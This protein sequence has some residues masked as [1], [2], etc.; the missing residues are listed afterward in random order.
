MGNPSGGGHQAG[1]GETAGSARHFRGHPQPVVDDLGA[2][3][4]PQ[5]PTVCSIPIRCATLNLGIGGLLNCTDDVAQLMQTHELDVLGVTETHIPSGSLVQDLGTEDGGLFSFLGP[6]STCAQL[7]SASSRPRGGVGLLFRC[8]SSLH[9]VSAVLMPDHD[10]RVR[11]HVAWFTLELVDERATAIVHV[12]VVYIPPRTSDSSLL[13]CDDR[14]CCAAN[15]ARDHTAAIMQQIRDEGDLLSRGNTGQVLL[16]GDFNAM[17]PIVEGNWEYCT[18][19]SAGA[20]RNWR[21][22]EPVLCPQRQVPYVL[23]NSTSTPLPTRI[24]PSSRAD[25][26]QTASILDLVLHQPASGSSVEDFWTEEVPGKDH[27]LVGFVFIA[28]ATPMAVVARVVAGGPPLFVTKCTPETHSRCRLTRIA[29]VQTAHSDMQWTRASELYDSWW[30]RML[31]AGMGPTVEEVNSVAASVLRQC[32]LLLSRAAAE[33]QDP[34]LLQLLQE[35]G[36][37]VDVASVNHVLLHKISLC[38]R[39]LKRTRAKLL[40]LGSRDNQDSARTI[41]AIAHRR[42]LLVT[43]QEA[44]RAAQIES[45]SHSRELRRD[46]AAAIAALQAEA[47]EAHDAPFRLAR[48]LGAITRTPSEWRAGGRHSKAGARVRRPQEATFASLQQWRTYLE[49]KYSPNVPPVPAELL[50]RLSVPVVDKHRMSLLDRDVAPAEVESALGQLR[51]EAAALAVPVRAFKQLSLAAPHSLQGLAIMLTSFLRGAPLPVDVTTVTLYPIL[52]PGKDAGSKDNWR[53]IGFGTTVSRVLQTV[54]ANRLKAFIVETKCL[55]RA[56]AGF[57][58]KLSADMMCWLTTVITEDAVLAGSPQFNSFVDVKAAFASTSH[59]DVAQSLMRVGIQ[60]DLASL[61]MS[62][63]TQS[64]VYIAEDGFRCDSVPATLGLIEGCSFSPLL[65]NIVMDSLLCKLDTVVQALVD[66]GLD[67]APLLDTASPLPATAYADDVRLIAHSIVV[68]QELLTATN[69]WMTEHGLQLGVASDKTAALI[70]AALQRMGSHSA[71]SALH[72]GDRELPLVSFY[73]YLGLLVHWKGV[74]ASAKAHRAMVLSRIRSAIGHLRFSGIRQ[75]RPNVGIIAYLTR[76]RPKLTYGLAMW[77]LCAPSGLTDLISDDY[78]AQSVLMNADGPLPHVVMN[79]LLCIPTLQCELDRCVVRLL[80]RLVALPEDDMYRSYLSRKCR[81]WNAASAGGRDR[82]K[83]TWWPRALARLQRLDSSVTRTPAS[84]CPYRDLGVR[85]ADTIQRMLLE[86]EVESPSAPSV[87][88]GHGALP[89]DQDVAE[90]F[91]VDVVGDWRPAMLA[92]LDR[93]MLYVTD[94][95][96]WCDNQLSISRM[97]S[98]VDTRDLVMGRPWDGRLPFLSRDRSVHQT[99]LMHLPAGTHYLFG[100]AHHDATCPWCK[101]DVVSVPHLLRDCIALMSGRQDAVSAMRQVAIDVGLMDVDTPDG[102]DAPG[103]TELWY[104]LMVGH[105]VPRRVG[106]RQLAF[107]DA[108]I[109]PS[110]EVDAIARTARRPSVARPDLRRYYRVLDASKGF[111]ITVLRRTQESFDVV[112][113][114]TFGARADPQVA[115]PIAECDAAEAQHRVNMKA[116]RDAAREFARV[117]GGDAFGLVPT[118]PVKTATEKTGM[119]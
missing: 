40:Q 62:F 67:V 49:H 108:L 9:A 19:R 55:H 33:V 117:N 78:H 28:V 59:L 6:A 37:G 34:T 65:W 27:W 101:D 107:V 83:D 16:L 14:F 77:G 75:V 72:V 20:A 93:C 41:R 4:A 24:E 23:V 13:Q 119:V 86:E 97:S 88:G 57:L 51:N 22:L 7:T 114:S 95:A 96:A 111:L 31:E 52:K 10:A 84:H 56:Q 69:D 44:L 47:A 90:G 104:H 46:Q 71:L 17:P 109:F 116:A 91:V 18:C 92:N 113:K 29:M 82:L 1:Q 11:Q 74:E 48:I 112:R 61:I 85:Y 64:H 45:R 5:P 26:H 76:V 58:P 21:L 53:T 32:G 54:I 15:C 25:L 103:Y 42:G 38:C 3:G 98:L 80:L 2:V 68:A 102:V 66:A 70:S 8:G 39:A 115:A 50:A 79:S 110:M 43:Q 63:L 87:V 30:E 73:K 99:Y 105:P 106:P 60:G 100:H 81:E 12:G 36:G 94:W 118:P 89:A 35:R